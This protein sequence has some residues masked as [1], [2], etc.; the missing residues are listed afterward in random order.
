MKIE[1]IV[2]YSIVMIVIVFTFGAYV[3]NKYG[4]NTELINQQRSVIIKQ[5]TLI[6]I[7]ESNNDSLRITR[8]EFDNAVKLLNE[9]K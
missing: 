3:G 9:K 8:T 6:E 7:L 4:I 2:W 1:T 5:R